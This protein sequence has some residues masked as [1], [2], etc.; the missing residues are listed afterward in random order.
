[1]AEEELSEQAEE[2]GAAP[3]RSR[4]RSKL[5]PIGCIGILIVAIIAVV[6]S[7]AFMTRQALVPPTDESLVAVVESP[8]AESGL[9]AEDTMAVSAVEIPADSQV[10]AIV[11]DTVAIGTTS[12]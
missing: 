10:A 1:M 4:L 11:G 3:A 8:P 7:G 12:T 9:P 2:A 6:G 5:L